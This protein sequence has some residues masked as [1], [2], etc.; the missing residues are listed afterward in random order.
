MPGLAAYVLV[1]LLSPETQ[2][3]RLTPSQKV[4]MNPGR[5]LLEGGVLLAGGTQDLS[6]SGHWVG[7][8]AWRRQ[9]QEHK[10]LA[11]MKK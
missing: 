4:A 8:V 7:E 3:H 2:L 9:R 1:S 5:L 10:E 6:L 11:T